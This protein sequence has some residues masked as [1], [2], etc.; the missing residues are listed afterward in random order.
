[1]Y[2]LAASSIDRYMAIKNPL[3][4]DVYVKQK[5]YALICGIWLFS[6]GIGLLPFII[7]NT[8]YQS[9]SGLLVT[10]IGENY[11]IIYGKAIWKIIFDFL[12]FN[13]ENNFQLSLLS[14]S[15][16][17]TI[18]D[19]VYQYCHGQAFDVVH[20]SFR[21]VFLFEVIFELQDSTKITFTINTSTRR[22]R[23]DGQN[24][25]ANGNC[26]YGRNIAQLWRVYSGTTFDA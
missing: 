15:A 21:V 1:M 5:I 7:P 8:F 16:G 9:T 17:A 10:G 26:I 19:M 2:L 13:R 11:F 12:K 6:I 20:V 22:R 25:D 3:R 18:Y 14:R 24:F 4:T 23:K